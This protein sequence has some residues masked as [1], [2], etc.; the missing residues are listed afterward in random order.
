MCSSRAP[1]QDPRRPHEKDPHARMT[2]TPLPSLQSST[3]NRTSSRTYGSKGKSTTGLEVK[4][5]F[6]YVC[7]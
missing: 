6:T 1:E 4:L 7:I 5:I 2:R 3:R